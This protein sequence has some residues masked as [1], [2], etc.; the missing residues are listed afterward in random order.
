MMN[1]WQS[2]RVHHSYDNGHMLMMRYYLTHQFTA[3]DYVI[4]QDIWNEFRGVKKHDFLMNHNL[5]KRSI[6][7][8]LFIHSVKIHKHFF[9]LIYHSY[10]L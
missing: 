1:N 9:K 6:N 10:G 5:R 8:K 2:E 3:S 4:F 7:N